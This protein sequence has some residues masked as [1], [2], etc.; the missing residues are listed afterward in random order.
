MFFKSRFAKRGSTNKGSELMKNSC[1][2]CQNRTVGCHKNCL[3]YV[4]YKE[5]IQSNK[6]NMKEDKSYGKY[7]YQTILRMKGEA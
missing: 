3:A 6:D 1:I 7:L 2:N 4:R 5:K